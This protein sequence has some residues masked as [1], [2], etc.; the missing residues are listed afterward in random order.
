MT[1][2]CSPQ[3][4][5]V[6]TS[7]TILQATPRSS[8]ILGCCRLLS[9]SWLQSSLK[10]VDWCENVLTLRHVLAADVLPCLPP[11][12][13]TARAGAGRGGGAGPAAD[14]SWQLSR[15]WCTSHPVL[16]RVATQCYIRVLVSGRI[17]IRRIHH[18]HSC[19]HWH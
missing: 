19:D 13:A 17:R 15:L 1:Q 4:C 8:P 3:T 6:T 7:S 9:F 10:T 16:L 12:L 18:Q 14:G 11:H 5:S 2:E